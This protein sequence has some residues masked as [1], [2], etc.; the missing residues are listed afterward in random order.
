MVSVS[1]ESSVYTRRKRNLLPIVHTDSVL[2]SK[3]EQAMVTA[4]R[5]TLGLLTERGWQW[6]LLPGVIVA[7]IA[8]KVFTAYKL[9]AVGVTAMSYSG[10]VTNV[11]VNMRTRPVWRVEDV[12]LMIREGKESVVFT[13]S[14]A[15]SI[16]DAYTAD[17]AVI[18]KA[19][20]DTKG[21]FV[22]LQGLARAAEASEET[23]DIRPQTPVAD[24]EPSR[25]V[26][27]LEPIEAVAD[28]PSVEEAPEPVAEVAD[29]EPRGRIALS[30]AEIMMYEMAHVAMRLLVA[31]YRYPCD[32]MTTT[33][34][35]PIAKRVVSKNHQYLVKLMTD[36]GVFPRLS[37]PRKGTPSV[38]GV[39]VVEYERSSR[40]RR[41]PN[42][43]TEA[44][45]TRV[46]SSQYGGDGGASRL[47][48]DIDFVTSVAK[49]TLVPSR[50]AEDAAEGGKLKAESSEPAVIEDPEQSRGVPVQDFTA[51]KELIE[52]VVAA[53]L[54]PLLRRVTELED[55]LMR[56]SHPVAP[57]SEVDMAAVEQAMFAVIERLGPEIAR[58]RE[59]HIERI[60]VARVEVARAEAEAEESKA[61]QLVAAMLKEAMMSLMKGTRT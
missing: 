21:A 26:E 37:S 33:I 11:G 18:M 58:E 1:V 28:V 22:M 53:R 6:P 25:V 50:Y 16:V 8:K 32:R 17:P 47:A 49:E 57:P 35:Y 31:N 13:E 36:K 54:A 30:D 19:S 10:I 56:H 43:V 61:K 38:F 3:N 51:T 14:D 29:V 34:L 2:A 55:L 5:L 60:S 12:E 41:K 59:R 44:E 42:V 15:C 45:V 24:P 48:W 40:I 20:T 9:P 46:I 27:D 23:P 52:A 7:A 4:M 39:N